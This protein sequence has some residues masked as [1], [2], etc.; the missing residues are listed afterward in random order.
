MIIVG[1]AASLVRKNLPFWLVPLSQAI[2]SRGHVSGGPPSLARTNLPGDGQ[3]REGF[4]QS[5]D[6]T[7]TVQWAIKVLFRVMA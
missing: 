6:V 2:W 3:T 1:S 4:I 7:P 5:G